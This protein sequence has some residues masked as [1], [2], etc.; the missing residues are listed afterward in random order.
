MLLTVTMM[1]ARITAF[2]SEARQRDTSI[3]ES[4]TREARHDA[5]KIKGLGRIWKLGSLLLPISCTF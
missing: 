4:Y 3:R 2:A 1:K 5:V